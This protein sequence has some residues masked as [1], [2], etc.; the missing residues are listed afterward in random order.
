MGNSKKRANMT[1]YQQ[2]KIVIRGLIQWPAYSWELKELWEH[3]KEVL[4][5]IFIILSRLV[6][7]VILPISAPIIALIIHVT[8][9]KPKE[10]GEMKWL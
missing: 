7:L 4:W 6:Y 10:T 9:D 8:K 5:I 2:L 3:V 1:Y